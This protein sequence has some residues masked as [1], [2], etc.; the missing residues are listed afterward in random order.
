MKRYVFFD[1]E[2]GEIVHTHQVYKLG[3]EKLQKVSDAELREL[4]NRMVDVGK[5]EH[6]LTS[7]PIQSSSKI[8]RYVNPKTRKLVTKKLSRNYWQKRTKSKQHETGKGG[9]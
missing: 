2:T 4:T 9:N 6:T 3:S 5:I 8:A 1:Q 7:A